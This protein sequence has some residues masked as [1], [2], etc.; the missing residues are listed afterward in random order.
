MKFIESITDFVFKHLNSED[1]TP[2]NKDRHLDEGVEGKSMNFI[3][4]ESN[5]QKAIV[6]SL[7]PYRCNKNVSQMTL[8]IHFCDYNAFVG[9]GLEHNA[10]PFIGG[11]TGRIQ[12]ELGVSFKSIIV[13]KSKPDEP[14]K[15]IPVKGK[16]FDDI[17]CFISE[18]HSYATISVLEGFGSLVDG[19]IKIEPD[20]TYYIGR[21]K[22]TQTGKGMI[23]IND[24]A[25]DDNP[26]CQEYELNKHVSRCH[27]HI[28]KGF[29]LY[30]DEGGTSLNKNR[31]RIQR[32]GQ[33]EFIDLMSDT[34]TP[35]SLEDGDIIELGK[36]VMLEFKLSV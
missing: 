29:M 11:L 3:E 10:N 28:G 1:N 15:C 8:S 21:G 22:R 13:K 31:T 30:V 6:K 36:K 19:A 34:Q 24:I 16:G 2:N 23:R 35:V 12:T 7:K 17:W 32:N 25:I 26:R 18:A 5:I 9:L 27:A 14:S 20:K 4:M 33:S